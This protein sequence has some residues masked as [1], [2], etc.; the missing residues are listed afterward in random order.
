MAAK[1]SRKAKAGGKKGKNASK[2]GTLDQLIDLQEGAIKYWGE[3]AQKTTGLLSRGTMNPASWVKEYTALS[4][5]V[6]KDI[7]EFVRIISASGR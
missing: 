3:Y 1:K 6:V 4:K 5:H 7:S 2:K